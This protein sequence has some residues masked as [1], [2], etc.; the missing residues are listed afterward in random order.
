MRIIIGGDGIKSALYPLLLRGGHRV[1]GQ[2]STLGALQAQVQLE[3]PDGLLL[4]G[5]LGDTPTALAAMVSRLGVPAVVLPPAHWDVTPLLPAAEVLEPDTTWESALAALVQQLP[6]ESPPPGSLLPPATPPPAAAP[7]APA[8]PPPLATPGAVDPLPLPAAAPTNGP[9]LSGPL[10]I[11]G[12]VGGAG[13]TSLALAL[14]AAVALQQHRALVLSS[15]ELALAGR[16]NL[17]LHNPGQIFTVQPGL[18]VAIWQ[19]QAVPPGYAAVII[20][21]QCPYDLPQETDATALFIGYPAAATRLS[22][23]RR[24]SEVTAYQLPPIALRLALVNRAGRG[25]DFGAVLRTAHPRLAV[26]LLPHDPRV[27]LLDD[28]QGHALDAPQ[29]GLAVF[30]LARELWPALFPEPTPEKERGP[31]KKEPPAVTG[32]PDAATKKPR[33]FFSIQLGD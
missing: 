24:I 32:K 33:K 13:A 3:R 5:V 21:T 28:T 11:Q 29:Y 30:N 22:L 14:G 18:D 19:E 16:L 12:L 2:A 15:D 23:L 1:L 7:P 6:G 17:A 27:P 20:E 26:T 4:A 10:L 9:L 31:G 8:G 25:G